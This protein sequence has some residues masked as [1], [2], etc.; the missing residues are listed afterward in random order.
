MKI[1]IQKFQLGGEFSSL[2]VNYIPTSA[3]TT[4]GA[5]A[6]AVASSSEDSGRSS[7]SSEKDELSI[8]D[9]LKVFDNVKGLP[10]DVQYVLKDF[11]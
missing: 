3:S 1:K 5:Y 2:A 9:V 6:P 11:K 7:K 10:I 4:A 8:K